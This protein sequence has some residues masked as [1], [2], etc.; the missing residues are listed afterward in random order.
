[1]LF[2]DDTSTSRDESAVIGQITRESLDLGTPEALKYVRRVWPRLEGSSGTVVK[3]RVG[4]QDEPSEGISWSVQ[5]DFR[6]N[7]DDFLNFDQSGRYISVR[8]EDDSAPGADTNPLWR[9]HGFDLE[10]TFQG[11]FSGA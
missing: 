3:V 11:D 5:Q 7:E 8:F 10:Y 2:V 1:L 9:V 4:V 6:I